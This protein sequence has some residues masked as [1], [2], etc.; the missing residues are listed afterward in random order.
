[1]KNTSSV[2]KYVQNI[3]SAGLAF[4]LLMF[5]TTASGQADRSGNLDRTVVGHTGVTFG[6]YGDAGTA[7][8]LELGM[9]LRAKRL[10]LLL[11][12]SQT[13]SMETLPIPFSMATITTDQILVPDTETDTTETEEESAPSYVTEEEMIFTISN[14]LTSINFDYRRLSAGGAISIIE[15][16][17]LRFSIGATID[18]IMPK[19]ASGSNL[20]SVDSSYVS[21]D[22]ENTFGWTVLALLEWRPHEELLIYLDAGYS[23]ASIDFEIKDRRMLAIDRGRTRSTSDLDGYRVRFGVGVFL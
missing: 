10:T 12:A 1:V 6:D 13:A 8:G 17:P 11:S 14:T 19:A 22:A 9:R 21:F 15:T 7:W 3:C 2:T 16:R 18:Y 20:T 5:A 23:A 4:A